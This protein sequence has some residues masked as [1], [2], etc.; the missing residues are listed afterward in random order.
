MPA[1]LSGVTAIAAGG[2]HTVAL[3]S[4]GAVAAWGCMVFDY[5]QSSV[6]AGLSGVTAI[7]AGYDH[8][9]ALKSDGTVVAWGLTT[10]ASSLPVGL[11]ASSP[12]LRV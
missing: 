11:S 9:V 2:Y 4:D 6:P 10:T 12:S 3:K 1:G 5:G 7:A 8:T